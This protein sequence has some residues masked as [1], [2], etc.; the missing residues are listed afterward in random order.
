MSLLHICGLN[1][2]QQIPMRWIQWRYAS[3][4]EHHT[5]QIGIDQITSHRIVHGTRRVQ[6][7]MCVCT[8]VG[9]KLNGCTVNFNS[10]IT[11]FTLIDLIRQRPHF[12]CPPFDK[13]YVAPFHK[14][15]LFWIDSPEW[16]VC[17]CDTLCDA[18]CLAFPHTLGS[19]YWLLAHTMHRTMQSNV[20][21]NYE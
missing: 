5:A 9:D 13:W 7:C 3:P 14:C 20:L 18:A 11:I 21:W 19:K 4:G 15:I 8:I 10:D 1:A 6:L 2:Q 17:V 16:C 12:M